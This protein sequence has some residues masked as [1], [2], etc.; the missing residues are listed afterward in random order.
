MPDPIGSGSPQGQSANVVTIAPGQLVQ[1]PGMDTPVPADQVIGF[2]SAFTKKTQELA[3]KTAEVDALRAQAE[4]AMMLEAA[5]NE[6]PFAALDTLRQQAEIYYRQNNLPIP[7]SQPTQQPSTPPA[8][9][10][11]PSPEPTPSAEVT[12]LKEELAQ[13]REQLKQM[14]DSF[15]GYVAG[16][17][18]RLQMDAL[19]A[20]NP[21]YLNDQEFRSQMAQVAQS[22]P[23]ADVESIFKLTA[24]ERL[25]QELQQ[26]DEELRLARRDLV[27][28]TPG[29]GFGTSGASG[30]DGP[31]KVDEDQRLTDI[32]AEKLDALV[33][34][35]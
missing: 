1:L 5:I 26:K 10:T 14:T 3:R 8:A 35:G 29:L 9:S 15:G 2:Q 18:V 28:S 24:Y 11:P 7:G 30:G 25:Q 20:K 32:L 4:K 34:G 22:L 27:A 33:Q 17:N 23:N 31:G 6:D 19:T 16:N 13:M 12:T 21:K